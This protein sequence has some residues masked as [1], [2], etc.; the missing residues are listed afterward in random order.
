MKKV[1]VTAIL[2]SF[3]INTATAQKRD[4]VQYKQ[5][6][7]KQKVFW[8]YYLGINN[9]DFKISYNTTDVF[10]NVKSSSG[11]EV[12]L[13]GDLRLHKNINLRLEPGLSSNTKTLEFTNIE[14][15]DFVRA[16]E[17]N[18]TYLRIPLLLKFSTD[19]LNNMRPYV[20]GGVSYD[21]NF[22]SNQDNPNDNLDGEFRMTK[23]NFMYEIG[24]GVDLYLPF[25]IFSPSIRG[26]FA[27]NDELVRDID[28][29]SQW[30]GPVDF[31]GTR[32]VFIKFA[33]H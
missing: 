11:F 31:L 26:V 33:F 3:L 1:F 15:N 22:S 4:V 10:I 2:I 18:G 29:N 14:G 32:G 20:I 6:W 24:I 25:F 12:G 16:R 7:D 5:N 17:V 19:R 27:I 30:T 13:I 21:Y 8:G 28:P 23:N 9:R